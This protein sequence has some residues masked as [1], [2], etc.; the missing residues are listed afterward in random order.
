[1]ICV[2]CPAVIMTYP[3]CDIFFSPRDLV[4]HFTFVLLLLLLNVLGVGQI[5][6]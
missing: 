5:N 3:A 2:V 4:V 1:M 6:S